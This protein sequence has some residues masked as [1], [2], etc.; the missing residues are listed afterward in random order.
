METNTQKYT[1]VVADDEEEL[2]RALIRRIDWEN[3]GFQVVGEAENGVEALELVER[4]EPDL[5]LTDVR[6]PFMTGIELARAV[7]EIR[8]TMQIAFLSGFDDFSYAQQA[9]QYN[10]ISYLLKPISSS[11]LSEELKKIKAKMDKKFEEFSRQ[12][13]EQEKNSQNSF[14]MSL[15]LDSFPENMGQ[16][17]EKKLLERAVENGF[18]ETKNSRLQYAVI[19]VSFQNEEGENC[20]TEANVNSV[21]LIL[22]K[23]MRHG[24]FYSN[25]RIVSLLCGTRGEFNKYLHILAEDIAQSV[26]RIMNLSAA[27]GISRTMAA[28]SDCH[29]AYIEA[30]NALEYTGHHDSGIHFITDIEHTEMLDQEKVLLAASEMESLLRGG[31][32]EELRAFL[33]EAFTQLEQQ[34]LMPAARQLFL[35]QMVASVFRVVYAVADSEAVQSLQASFPMQEKLLFEEMQNSWEKYMAFCLEARN[36][37][38]EQRRKSGSVI[39]DRALAIIESSYKNPDLSLV[40]VSSEISVSPNYLSAQ[41]KKITGRTF[42]DLLTGRRMEKAKELLLE[43]SMK[44]REISE[45]CG[46]NDQHYFS[47]CFKKYTGV[48]PNACRRQNEISQAEK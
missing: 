8:P 20:T 16:E 6:M 21:D 22:R 11:E 19:A 3:I 4:L 27:V 17:Q 48:S 31:S 23:Y 28:L 14:L 29:E 10:I 1:I 38:A 18:L 37:I 45:Q 41:M 44:I 42:I 13:V 7:R 9:I 40:S 2:R 12:A 33:Q 43:T 26:K 34:E 25:G 15:L 39:C 46:Y 24:S 47:Y 30:V 32:E 35:V 5:L 36:L